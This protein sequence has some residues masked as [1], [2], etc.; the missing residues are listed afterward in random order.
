MVDEW[1][2][3]VANKSWDKCFLLLHALLYLC[4]AT[5]LEMQKRVRDDT[6]SITCTGALLVKIAWL[7]SA[8]LIIDNNQRLLPSAYHK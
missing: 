7:L 8:A 3:N 6:C 1:S 5:H 4:L 2:P